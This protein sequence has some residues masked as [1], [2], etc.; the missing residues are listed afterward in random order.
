MG[1]LGFIAYSG[2]KLLLG[3]CIAYRPP[4]NSKI[5]MILDPE[6]FGTYV[7]KGMY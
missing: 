5:P 4:K 7:L 2:R 6:W 3:H 1:P